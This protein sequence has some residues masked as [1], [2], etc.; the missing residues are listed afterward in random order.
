VRLPYELL[1][2]NTI[3][4][5]RNF[6]NEMSVGR[7][8]SVDRWSVVNMRTLVSHTPLRYVVNVAREE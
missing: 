1:K 8:L 6:P 2:Y 4:Y 3:Q 5:I 7:C